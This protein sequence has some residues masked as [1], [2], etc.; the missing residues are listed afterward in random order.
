VGLPALPLPDGK[1]LF[2]LAI[3]RCAPFP[4]ILLEPPSDIVYRLHG[5]LKERFLMHDSQR[6]GIKI[7][8]ILGHSEFLF[9]HSNC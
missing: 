3:A 8:Y 1:R 4:G 6:N 5:Q 7:I 2:H 9:A